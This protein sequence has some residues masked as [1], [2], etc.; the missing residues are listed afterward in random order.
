MK[1]AACSWIAATTAGWQWPVLVTAMPL[2]KS[3][4]SVPSTVV[5]M[6]P[7]PDTTSRSVTWNQT[8]AREEPMRRRLGGGGPC[9]LRRPRL[10]RGG[11][12]PRGAL[13]VAWALLEGVLVPV[14]ALTDE[15]VAAVHVERH[16]VLALGVRDRVDRLGAHDE[17][18]PG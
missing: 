18:V 10:V 4:Y 2:V 1:R 17:H 3:R 8:S 7:E 14:R 5:T 9:D 11:E 12:A 6:Q 16:R 13:E 15:E